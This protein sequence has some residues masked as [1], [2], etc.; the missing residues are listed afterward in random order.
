MCVWGGATTTHLSDIVI[1]REKEEI[2]GKQE[3]EE[4]EEDEEETD[5]DR[6]FR[7]HLTALRSVALKKD[8]EGRGKADKY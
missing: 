5:E 8:V 2:K 3:E 7:S 6:I 1:D 4:R